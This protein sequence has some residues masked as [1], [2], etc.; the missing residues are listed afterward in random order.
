MSTWSEVEGRHEIEKF[1]LFIRYSLLFAG[2]YE[3]DYYLILS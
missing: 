3:S 1:V 2:V